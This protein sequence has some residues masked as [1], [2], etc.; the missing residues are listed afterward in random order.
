MKRTHIAGGVAALLAAALVP[1]AA[2][3]HHGW[4]GNDSSRPLNVT[5]VIRESGYEHPHGFVRLEAPGK[6][7]NVVLAPPSRMERRGLPRATLKPGATATVMGYPHRTDA[8]E[9]RA[10]RIT[11][12]GKT[13]ELR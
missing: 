9:M 13:T 11:I 12:D 7:W 3:A 2:R 10:E 5:G 4:S 8:E 6:T 1:A